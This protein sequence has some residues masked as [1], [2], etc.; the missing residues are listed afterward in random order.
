M[1]TFEQAHFYPAC[2]YKIERTQP[3]YRVLQLTE[4]PRRS[5]SDS[6]AGCALIG[7]HEYLPANFFAF[8]INFVSQI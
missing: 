6:E 8:R 4:D 7:L 5:F 1:L 2:S 3:L